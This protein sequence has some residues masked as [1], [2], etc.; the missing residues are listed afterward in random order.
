MRQKRNLV[1]LKPSEESVSRT[2]GSIVLN[3]VVGARKIKT[4]N[5]PWD[6]VMGRSVTRGFQWSGGSEIVIG[7]DLRQYVEEDL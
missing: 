1:S 5:W 2:E 7:A 6:L 3:N 4:K